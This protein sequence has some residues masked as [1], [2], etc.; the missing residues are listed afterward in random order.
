MRLT[1]ARIAAQEAVCWIEYDRIEAECNLCWCLLP[2]PS[3]IEV[4]QT[5]KVMQ[6]VRRRQ[7]EA[8]RNRKASLLSYRTQLRQSLSTA[9]NPTTNYR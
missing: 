8:S 9:C 7:Q 3:E 4:E 6:K 5:R 1:K 2:S